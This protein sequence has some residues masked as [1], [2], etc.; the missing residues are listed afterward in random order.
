MADT[1]SIFTFWWEPHAT[2]TFDPPVRD[3]AILWN[4]EPL[5]W[6]GEILTWGDPSP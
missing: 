1:S 5:T 2:H 6:D 3:Y 4:G